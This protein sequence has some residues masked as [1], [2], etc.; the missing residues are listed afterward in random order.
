MNRT[1]EKW[2]GKEMGRVE[3][4]QYAL[5]RKHLMQDLKD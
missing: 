4:L 2:Q 3:R 5:G 1:M